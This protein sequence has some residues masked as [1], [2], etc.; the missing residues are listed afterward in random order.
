MT[1]N[2]EVTPAFD[3]ND[4]PILSAPITRAKFLCVSVEEKQGG[5]WDE[6]GE[7]YST[8][9]YYRYQFNVVLDGS[10]ENRKF[11]SSTPSGSVV[12]DCVRKSN[13]V[14]GKAYYLDFSPAE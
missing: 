6:N 14:T 1:K 5:L 4:T 8:G 3:P 10:E 12:L 13:F 11:F 2:S 9:V 7:N